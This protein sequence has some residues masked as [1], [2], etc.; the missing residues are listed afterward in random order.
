MAAVFAITL[1]QNAIGNLKV[2]EVHL[3]GAGII[4]TALALVLSLSI[5]P[6]Q[7]AADVFSSAI[8][9]LYARDRTTLAVFALLSC[10]AL[11][12]LTFGT[13]WM[14][15]LSGRYTLAAQLVLLGLS[16]D[17]LRAFYTRALSL[18]DPV[19][20]LSLVNRECQSY[21]DRTTE[22]VE[23]LARAHRITAGVRG[24]E[25]AARY[26]IHTRSNLAAGLSG[27]TAQLEEFA[28]KGVARRD[29][30]AVTAIVN[31]MADIGEKYSEARRDSMFLLPDFTG[32]LPISVSDIR[33]VLDP[34]HESIKRV[35]EDAVKQSNEAIVQ[36]CLV[37]LGRMAADIIPIEE[38]VRRR[39][40]PPTAATYGSG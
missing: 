5:A 40:R 36:G 8:L 34:I 37:A 17:A 24:N 39:V 31:A 38:H 1:P 12:S 9:R 4:G 3:A 20:A 35:C 6:A 25:A 2:S 22:S 14:F 29:T 32:G 33:N 16:L 13:G 30:Q 11:V 26:A 18:L 28:H 21:I 7:K 23:R 27:W 19:I 10:T 15:S